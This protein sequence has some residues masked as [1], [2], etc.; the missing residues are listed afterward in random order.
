MADDSVAFIYYFVF[1]AS[2]PENSLK[3]KE[4]KFFVNYSVTAGLMK[5]AI[6]RLN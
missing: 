3:I 4:N 6:S 5:L 2:F 1:V